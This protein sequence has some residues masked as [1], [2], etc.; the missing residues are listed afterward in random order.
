MTDVDTDDAIRQEAQRL[1]AAEQEAMRAAEER[2]PVLPGMS[3]NSLGAAQVVLDRFFTKDGLRQLAYWRENWYSY[4]HQLWSER[5]D[6]DV[7]HFIH[8]RL[9]ECRTVDN[10]GNVI[11]FNCAQKNVNEI[12]FQFQQ[13]TG[14][15]SHVNAPAAYVNGKW[16][17]QDARGKIVCRGQIVDM[18]T[19]KVQSNQHMF[20]PNG[21]EWSWD[22]KAKEPEK[23]LQFMEELFMGATSEVE[24]LQEWMGY[25]LSGDTW[26]HKGMILVGPP[27]AG[28]GTIG[29]ILTR[30]LG[31]SMV[32]SP[33]LHSLGKDFGLQPLLDK[34]LCMVS[35]ARLSNKADVMSVIEVL[36]RVTAGDP[37]DVARKHKAALMTTLGARVML[38][39]NEMPT[40]YDSSDAINTRFLILQLSNSFLGKENHKLV[41]QLTEELPAIAKWCVEGYKRLIERGRFAEPD[42][43]TEAR[44]EWYEENNPLAQF[45][46]DR[47]I[48]GAD[49]KV[50]MTQLYE[51]YK[52]WSEARGIPVMAANALSRRLS[53]QLVGKV[54]K[55]KSGSVRYMYGLSVRGDEI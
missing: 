6:D 24:L 35:D 30:L 42:T 48:L 31:K 46:E 5:T 44:K 14:I 28:K 7:S 15:P 29:H 38:L 3:R 2:N 53:A 51:L 37:V 8:R 50:E 41:D 36:L 32:A 10:E 22:K 40:L 27:R 55:G 26:A 20:I 23:W 11:D 9:Q 34:R 1:L 47:C 33:T 4:Y 45:V 43:S 18:L 21:A 25:V 52:N 39:S 17:E 13:L 49:E 19:G 54:R 12:K 16:V